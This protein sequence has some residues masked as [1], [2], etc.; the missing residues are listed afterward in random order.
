[1][2][3]ACAW[4]ARVGSTAPPPPP[5]HAL[6]S[7]AGA[8]ACF[9]PYRAAPY[10]GTAPYPGAAPYAGAAWYIITV[11]PS[12]GQTPSSTRWCAS[13]RCS[14]HR[15]RGQKQHQHSQSAKVFREGGRAG[16]GAE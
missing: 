12:A 7:G 13:V 11:S 1:M 5:A 4:G 10:P 14:W 15:A 8:Y 9:G 3:S 2:M 16:A 6:S